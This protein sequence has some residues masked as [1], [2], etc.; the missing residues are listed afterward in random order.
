MTQGHCER[1]YCTY[2]ALIP[3]CLLLHHHKPMLTKLEVGPP[4][5]V[6]LGSD[7]DALMWNGHLQTHSGDHRLLILIRSQHTWMHAAPLATATGG[8]RVTACGL[9]AWEPYKGSSKNKIN[10]SKKQLTSLGAI[11][12]DTQHLFNSQSRRLCKSRPRSICPPPLPGA[13]PHLRTFLLLLRLATL[14]IIRRP[15]TSGLTLAREI[16]DGFMIDPG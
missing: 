5:L 11:H 15:S 12:A 16:S 1:L 14:L 7:F 6:G 9:V 13:L 10:K 8:T 3:S 4:Q 2:K